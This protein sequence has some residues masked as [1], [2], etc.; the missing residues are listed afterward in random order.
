MP[1]PA[2]RPTEVAKANALARQSV[3]YCSGSH[4]VYIAK[5]APPTPSVKRTIMNGVRACGR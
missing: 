3:A 5:L 4:N 2:N 1:A